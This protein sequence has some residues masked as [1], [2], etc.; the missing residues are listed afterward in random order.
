MDLLHKA[1]NFK[2]RRV[3]PPFSWV[4]HIPFAAMLVAET[5]PELIVELGTHTGNSYFTFCQAVE[6]NQL[7]TKCYAV[8]S[9]QGEA[10]AGFYDESVFNDVN[11]YNKEHYSKFSYLLRTTFDEAVHQFADN[12]IDILHIDGLHTYEA[13]KNDYET[14]LPKVK[15]GAV[16]LFHD[17]SCYHADF[18]VWKLWEELTQNGAGSVSFSHSYGLGMLVKKGASNPNLFLEALTNSDTSSPWINVFAPAGNAIL[19]QAELIAFKKEVCSKTENTLVQL[20]VKSDQHFCEEKSIRLLANKESRSVL[21]FNNLERFLDAGGLYLRLDPAD[22]VCRVDLH[23]A[24]LIIQK[25]NGAIQSNALE[26]PCAGGH[27][28]EIEIGCKCYLSTNH[29]PQL[30]FKPIEIDQDSKISL[31][32]ELTISSDLQFIGEKLNQCQATINQN[33]VTIASINDQFNESQ[34]SLGIIKQNYANIQASLES[35]KLEVEKRDGAI[36]QIH[37]QLSDRNNTL[38]DIERKLSDCEYCIAKLQEAHVLCINKI[39]R[40]QNSV[41][42][43]LTSP[44]RAIRRLIQKLI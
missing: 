11:A 34:C 29:D 31:K 1:L 43:I 14:W 39:A 9:W 16:I 5:K 18:G 3:V 28:I 35:S 25:S 32:V 10:H 26:A 30:H 44:L 42:W 8:D 23:S 4:G 13:V 6:E 15:E 20:F 40:M 37:K 27:L 24:V 17:I 22:T 36:E 33:E 2:P 41:S 38:A 19:T 12:S 7:L 21:E